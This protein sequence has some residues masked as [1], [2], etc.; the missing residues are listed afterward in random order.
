MR[1]R[2][3]ALDSRGEV[4]FAEVAEDLRADAQGEAQL[5]V[6]RGSAALLSFERM[7]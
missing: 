7:V 3:P 2:A 1:L 6:P 4:S 5:I